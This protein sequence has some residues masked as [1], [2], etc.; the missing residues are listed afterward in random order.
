[1]AELIY[2][3]KRLAPMIQKYGIDVEN[4][5]VFQ[6]I[7][8]LFNGQTD[9]QMWAIKVVYGRTTTL[10]DL[11]DIKAWA[12]A[13]PTEIAHLSM[14]NL[15]SYKTSADIALLHNEMQNLDA[16]RLVK[17]T[18][19]R[20]NTAQRHALTNTILAR[21]Q[22]TP[23][24]ALKDSLFKKFYTVAKSFDILPAHRQQKFMS[25]MSAVTDVNSIMNHMENAIQETYDWNREDMLSYA[26][27][28]CP[29]VDVVYDKDNVVIARIPSFESSQKLCGN[30]RTS[31]CLTRDRGYFTR[32]T[33]EN[34][35][36]QQ[37]FLFDFNRKEN[38][39]L[40]HVGFSVNPARGINYAHSTRN[41]NLMG[42][43]TVDGNSWDI[44]KVLKH[45]NI[46]KSVYVRL[47]KL[48]AYKWDKVSFTQMLATHH[49]PVTEL[50]DG[51]L[52]V[53][54]TDDSLYKRIMGHTLCPNLNTR[55]NKYFALFDFSKD[56]D[57][58]K[59]IL[60][61]AFGKDR[62]ETL[63]FKNMYDAYGSAE[64]NPNVLGKNHVTS[65]MFVKQGDINPNILLHKLI[66]EENIKAAIKLLEENKDIDPEYSI[67]FINSC[68]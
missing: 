48:T 57:N 31:W 67:L 39:D 32:Y 44:H 4:D 55:E 34:E 50:E 52:I 56:V 40:A 15:V 49:I 7:I 33:K 24:H 29:D 64:S 13:N 8:A 43:V 17:A 68:S 62:Y 19:N 18:I 2:A 21:V 54:I 59:S 1:M 20:F 37:F 66:D 65:D 41:N 42:S 35:N 3:K 27:R 23:N 10:D 22:E 9:Y 61:F 58:D 47:K 30:G 12:D 51:R 14:H 5:K 6:S 46:E 38:H 63:S 28:C 60:L 45:H 16:V 53:T 26:Q 25:L 11:N 36:A